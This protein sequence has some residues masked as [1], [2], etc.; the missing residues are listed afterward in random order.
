M[1]QPDFCI[2]SMTLLDL[3]AVQ[4]I[5]R[6][7]FSL[8]WP[9]SAFRYEVSQSDHSRNYVLVASPGADSSQVVAM[10]VVW[11]IVDEAHIATI[12]VHPDWRG[13]GLGSRLLQ[14]ILLDVKAIGMQTALLEVRAGNQ[15][16]QEMYRKFGFEVVGRRPRYY[17][18]NHEDALLMNLKLNHY[19]EPVCDSP[20]VAH[21]IQNLEELS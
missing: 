11:V 12:A 21:A 19:P 15:V 16:A 2:R 14:H 10:A 5:D 1:S 18:D 7:S 6:L 20:A 17:K 8:P 9:E 13:Q 3:D 4:T